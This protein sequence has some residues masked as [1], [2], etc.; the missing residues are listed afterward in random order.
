VIQRWAARF[1]RPPSSAGRRGLVGLGLA[2]TALL[3]GLGSLV[4]V[5]A[6][7]RHTVEEEHT[8]P[9]RGSS[10][11]IDLTVGEVQIVPSPRDE[12]ISVRRRLT[13]GLRRPFVEERVDGDT[14][15]VRDGNCA[16]RVAAI[17]HVRWLL[18][19]PRDVPVDVTTVSGAIRVTALSGPVKLTSTSG[20][21]QARTLSGPSVQLLSHG[22]AVKGT[23]LRS[24][25][26][27]ATSQ[28]GAVSLGFSSNPR[29]VLAQSTTGDVGVVLPHGNEA[30][31]ITAKAA[32]S[33]TI[34][35]KHDPDAIRSVTVRSDKGDVSILQSP[36]T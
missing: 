11:S 31:R 1:R 24:S 10:V 28:T 29:F 6:M 8:Y 35:A 26:V 19:V 32:G 3:V 23:D 4:A 30:Y 16:V 12:E 34:A 36:E 9:F 15:V 27:V 22:G 20:L 18:A 7:A 14:F 21:V 13:Y 2:L 5:N 17:C 33:K 25:H